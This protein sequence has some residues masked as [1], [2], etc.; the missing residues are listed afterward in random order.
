[1]LSACGA[2][3]G[4]DPGPFQTAPTPA[5]SAPVGTSLPAGVQVE[6]RQSRAD[7]AARQAMVSVTNDSDRAIEVGGVWIDDPRFVAPAE[8]V[9]ERTSR[10]PAGATVDIRVQ[11]A[12]VRCDVPDA[13]QV[14]ATMEVADGGATATAMAVTVPVVDRVPFLAELHA[15]E[16]LQQRALRSAAIE[17]GGFAPS[18][19]GKPAALRLV[20]T[21]TSGAGALRI[22]GIRETNLLTFEGVVDG[23]HRLDLDQTGTDRETQTVDLPLV[24]LRCDPHAVQEDKRGTVFRLFVEVDGEPGSFD[25]AATP[26]LRGEIL[27]WIAAWCGF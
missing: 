24:P 25:L 27:D 14:T 23:L 3:P 21:P 9:V 22:T 6:V 13:A 17:I 19:P 11:L 7:V 4:P 10:V 8:R 16:C 12:E 20:V 15:R 26:V 1:M 5:A 2:G 18:P